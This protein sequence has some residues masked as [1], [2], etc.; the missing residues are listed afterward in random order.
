[1]KKIF[2]SLFALMMATFTFSSCEDVP[3]PYDTPTAGGGDNPGDD[4][5]LGTIF[6]E[7]FDGGSNG[8]TLQNVTIPSELS[9]VW[10]VG[11][12]N[13]NSYL[14][15]SA[16]A[17]SAS[18]A[19]EAWAV[20]PAIDLTDSHKAVLTFRHA[21]NKL[22][23]VSTMKDMMTVWASTDYSND[24]KTATWTK[25]TVPTYPAGTSWTWVE[26]GDID[27]AAYCGKKVTIAFK[28]TSTDTN[29]GGWEVDDFTVK[30]DGTAMT[31]DTPDTPDQPQGEAKGTGTQADPFNVVAAD[32]YITDGGDETKEVFVKGK[33]VGTPSF[34]SKY[35]S[36]TYNISDD[37]TENGKLKVYG[38]KGLGGA[39]FSS[40]SD[41]KAGDE[42]IICGK[43]VNYQGTHEF[44]SNNYLYSLNGTTVEPTT[45]SEPSG[46]GKVEID[47]ATLT[48]VNTKAGEGT[49][50]VTFVPKE[51]LTGNGVEVPTVTLSDGTVLMFD[52]GSG[53]SVPKYYSG[54]TYGN[55]RIYKN[56]VV[57]IEGKK[58]IA[59]VVIT[60]DVN[61]STVYV[62]NTTATL[63]IS[64]N[65]FVYT[66]YSAEAGGQTQL[67]INS[68]TIYYA[69]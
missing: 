23:D 31:P 51:E 39:N 8:F 61:G 10:K 7:N 59:K 41:L 40:E 66:N 47:N 36:M 17:N 67:R 18:H 55:V 56:N 21:I 12:Y 6:T 3:A 44:T 14:N 27:L 25:L 30:G 2:Y 4:S 33:V 11:N 58:A 62:G 24:V 20:S 68:I 22:S 69:K 32:K 57:K 35:N 54:A 5:S 53:T 13:N 49:E 26:S 15:A 38:G 1:M 42:V 28:Y 48:L 52:Q 65:T 37:G 43:L 19:T 60:G 45:P 16:F 63:S 64:G 34:S 46:D 50:S 29:S 9:Y